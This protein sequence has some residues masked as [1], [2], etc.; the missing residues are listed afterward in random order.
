MGLHFPRSLH[1][2]TQRQCAEVDEIT[3]YMVEC[4]YDI[5]TINPKKVWAENF[6]LVAYVKLRT[7]SKV[8]NTFTILH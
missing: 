2:T 3:D 7:P 4:I 8:E 5:H 6:Q 1:L